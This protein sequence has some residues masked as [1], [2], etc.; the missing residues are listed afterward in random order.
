VVH[1]FNE[2]V[3]METAILLFIQEYIRCDFLN[4]IVIFITHLGDAGIF[5]ILLT[6]I[7][8]LF[9]KTRPIAYIMTVSM[10]LSLLINNGILKNTV[11]RIRPYDAII[12]L[13]RIIEAQ[14]DYSFPSGH[15]ACSFA[16]AI[17]ILK[18]TDKKYGIPVVI[19]A[20]FISLSRL[21]V[22]VHYPT[23]VL[24][25][26]VSGSIIACLS[27]FLFKKYNIIKNEE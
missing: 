9:K 15:S 25:G 22:G 4:P 11:M 7:L 19:L 26:I 3:N 20:L 13:N 14:K 12:G 18:T 17:V 21:Y 6:V 2:E 23:D 16:A 1:Y 27:V 24:F 8:L 5:W 10:V